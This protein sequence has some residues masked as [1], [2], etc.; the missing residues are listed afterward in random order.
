[1]ATNN[2]NIAF[3]TVPMFIWMTMALSHPFN[4]KEDHYAAPL[5]TPLSIRQR[6]DVLGFVCLGSVSSSSTLQISKDKA[7]SDSWP[8]YLSVSAWSFPLTLACLGAGHY[9]HTCFWRWLLNTDTC[10]SGLPIPPLVTSS[11]NLW[12]WWHAWSHCQLFWQFSGGQ[13][14]CV[15]SCTSIVKMEVVH[16]E[17][18][19]FSVF[20][21][22]LVKRKSNPARNPDKNDLLPISG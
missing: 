3:E 13:T 2:N 12:R 6:C 20:L 4:F 15:T 1:M 16:H 21:M 5:P 17:I 7:N 22:K 18:L 9:I 14:F 19:W 11:L 10:Q 8:A